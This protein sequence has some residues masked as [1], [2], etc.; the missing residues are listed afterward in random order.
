MAF[1]TAAKKREYYAKNVAKYTQYK[2]NWRTKHHDLSVAINRKYNKTINGRF[3]QYRAAAKGR[4]LEF[5]LSIEDFEYLMTQFCFYCGENG[6][7][8]DRVD[9]NKGYVS[10]NVVSCCWRC[11]DMKGTTPQQDFINKCKLIAERKF[12]GRCCNL[13]KHETN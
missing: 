10:T 1:K 7:G 4:G 11:N 2:R 3:Q 13:P 12:Y 5:K 9:S 8:I 6:G